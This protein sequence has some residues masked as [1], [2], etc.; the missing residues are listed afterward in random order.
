MMAPVHIVL[1]VLALPAAAMSC[2]LLVL[3][4]LSRAPARPPRC[5]S[6]TR[7][8]V[9]VPA[10]DEAA[11]IAHAVASLQAL[12]WPSTRFR[13]L[14]VADNCS[15]STA[16]LARAAGAEVIER[17]DEAGRGKGYAL[18]F[19][20]ARLLAQP[21]ADALV[22]VDADSE[23]SPNL[24]EAFARC[25]EAGAG[26]V[27][28]HHGV[29][30]AQ[31]SWRTRLMTIALACF[32]RL[33]SRAR[34]RL[35]L[36]C[37]IRGN[38]WCVTSALLRQVPFRAYSLAEDLE[39]GIELGLA[40]HRVHY[41]DEAQV[42]AMMVSSE[43]A[44]RSQRRR[45]EDGRLQLIRSRTGPLLAR[46]RRTGSGVCLDLALDL[47]VPPLSYLVL[48]IAILM[49]VAAGALAWSASMSAWLWLGAGCGLCLAAYVLRGWQLSRVGWRGLV[50]LMRVPAFVGWK[51]LLMLRPHDSAKWVRTRREAP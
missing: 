2:Y 40:G 7:F 3:T 20:F 1:L 37:G 32:H 35:K 17:C 12:Q 45:W 44:A 5:A 43:Q 14:V 47:L 38:G 48:D 50:D 9:V 23:V 42:D 34:E 11:V 39:Y 10:H 33:R 6:T 36:S 29:M 27:Q 22:V 46:W 16:A 28:A 41:A 4:L 19:A 49:A 30:N 13:L 25:I 31:S 18:D 8:V 21:W 15:D 51:V 24:L 26:A